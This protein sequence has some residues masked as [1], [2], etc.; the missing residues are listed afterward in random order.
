MNQTFLLPLLVSVAG[1]WYW[2]SLY[3]DYRVSVFRQSLFSLRD[4]LFDLAAR[5]DLGFDNTA[6]TTLRRQLNGFIRFGDRVSVT[7]IIGIMFAVDAAA[8]RDLGPGPNEL[9]TDGLADLP[10]SV[11]EAILEIQTAMH[12]ELATQVVFVSPIM[13]AP[14]ILALAIAMCIE[15]ANSAMKGTAAIKDWLGRSYTR[16]ADVAAYAEGCLA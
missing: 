6:Y 10:A 13:L 4:Q 11:Q 8:Q 2:L 9:M 14:I 3:R 12:H 5:G 7:W 15:V 16:Q 1:F